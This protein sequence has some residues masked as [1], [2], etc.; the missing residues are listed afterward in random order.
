M[1]GLVPAIFVSDTDKKCGSCRIYKMRF[2]LMRGHDE[3]TNHAM[4]L[5]SS[6]DVAIIGHGAA[7]LGAANALKHSGLS[8]LVLEARDRI[9]GRAHT[10]M[11]SPDVTFDLSCGWLHTADE[12]SFVDIAG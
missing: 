2:A 6:V 10:I 9:G 3:E 5:P 1:A 7:G 4:S 12:N 8:T 11:A